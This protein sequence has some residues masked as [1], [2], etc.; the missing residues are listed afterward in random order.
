MFP[1]VAK[2]LSI[3]GAKVHFSARG[4]LT[5]VRARFNVVVEPSAMSQMLQALD[6]PAAFGRFQPS[7]RFAV[8][9]RSIA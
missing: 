3:D 6:R 1:N 2:L 7:L 8:R 9:T 4:L 5:L